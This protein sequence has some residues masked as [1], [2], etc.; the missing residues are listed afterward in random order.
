MK[1][2]KHLIL[3]IAMLVLVNCKGQ[4]SKKTNDHK[5]YAMNIPKKQYFLNYELFMS[6]ELYINDV[7]LT[8]NFQSGP[9]SGMEYLN[10]YILNSGKQTIT[11]ID[12]DLEPDSNMPNDIFKKISLAIYSADEN[13][14]NT[15]LEKKFDFPDIPTPRPYYYKNTWEFDAEVPYTVDGWKDGQDLSKIDQKELKK[16]VVAKFQ[17]LRTILNQG[18][19]D[20]FME[21]NAKGYK[22]FVITNYYQKKWHEFDENIRETIGNQKGIMLPL[23]HYKM[24]IVA[25]GQLVTL[26]RINL[27]YKGQSALLAINEKEN[28]I[29][30]DY[31]HLYMPKGKTSLEPIRLNIEY[32]V[33]HF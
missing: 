9:V 8:N 16:M 24:K 27:P 30:T 31:I 28:T 14:E 1:S 20:Q 5:K 15:K 32:E 2:Q 6:Y 18:K 22:E 11:L 23:E 13:D 4:E 29:Y 19:V 12:R 26:E 25:N 7:K 21:E 3:S 10:D 33:A 17:H